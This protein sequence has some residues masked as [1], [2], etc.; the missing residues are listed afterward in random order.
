[1]LPGGLAVFEAVGWRSRLLGLAF[2]DVLPRDRALLIPRCRSVHTFGMRF[3]IE[4]V[5][6]DPEGLPVRIATAAPP[7][8]GFAA[9]RAAAVVLETAGG[10]AE[11]FLEAGAASLNYSGIV[12]GVGQMR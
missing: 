3:P 7:R 1:V 8:R 11:R 6:L 12:R 2:L 9:G 4:G 10:Q 5:F